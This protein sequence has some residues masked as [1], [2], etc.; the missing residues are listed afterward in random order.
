MR[1]IITGSVPVV[2][3]LYTMYVIGTTYLKQVK[4]LWKDRMDGCPVEEGG[5]KGG[6]NVG[7]IKIPLEP[8]FG[9]GNILMIIFYSIIKLVVAAWSIGVGSVLVLLFVLF[10]SFFAIFIYKSNGR[11]D[12]ESIKPDTFSGLFRDMNMNAS[13]PWTTYKPEG[14]LRNLNLGIGQMTTFLVVLVTSIYMLLSNA[15]FIKLPFNRIFF[16]TI[17]ATIALGTSIVIMKY[18]DSYVKE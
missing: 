14:F 6:M 1:A 3:T 4:N 7:G 15:I 10:H 2:I 11:A 16:S 8:G 17:L 5:I 12:D 9:F 18:K 13:E